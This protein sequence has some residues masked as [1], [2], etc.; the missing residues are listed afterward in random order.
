[1][2][3]IDTYDSC[4][5]KI[6]QM[7]IHLKEMKELANIQFDFRVSKFEHFTVNEIQGELKQVEYLIGKLKEDL[8]KVKDEDFNAENYGR[9]D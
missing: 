8:E 5:E 6:K 3:K 7:E 1:M 2:I 9:F 4:N